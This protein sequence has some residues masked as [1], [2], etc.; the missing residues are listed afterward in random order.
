M[1]ARFKRLRHWLAGCPWELGEVDASDAGPLSYTVYC[2]EPGCE[3]QMRWE[4]RP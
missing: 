4:P 3:K 2:P 1:W